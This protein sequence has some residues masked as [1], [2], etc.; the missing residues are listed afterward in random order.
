M[1]IFATFSQG[2]PSRAFVA[3]P[4]PCASP[5]AAGPSLVPLHPLPYLCVERVQYTC[6]YI[7][8]VSQ[9]PKI[10]LGCC[11]HFR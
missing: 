3:A 1:V 11:S 4:A 8:P 9:Y 6:V 7:S 10:S 5:Y 2:V